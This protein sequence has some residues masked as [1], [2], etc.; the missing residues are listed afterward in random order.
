M[1][2]YVL[3]PDE[4]TLLAA[5]DRYVDPI[6]RPILL[7]QT[8]YLESYMYTDWLMDHEDEWKDEDWVGCI[9]HRAHTKQPR[10]FD[11][12]EVMETATTQGA[13]CCA[14]MYRGDPLLSTA[15]RWHPGFREA[16]MA[17]W[18]S[19]GWDTPMHTAL[20]QQESLMLSFYCNYWAASP[21]LMRMYCEL[22]GRLRV[23]IDADATLRETLWR[24][25]NYT[26]RGQEIASIPEDKCMALW[27]VPYYPMV[28]FV[29][30][31]MPCVFFPGHTKTLLLR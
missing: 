3:A 15:E 5:K 28:V 25:S 20:I 22:M 9:A 24:D 26:G 2:I 23:A 1:L 18:R 21:R 31:R 4:D 29:M 7:P 17:A 11:I 12:R 14:F 30:E 13:E 27:G 8:P 19:A 6:F 10:I 16:W